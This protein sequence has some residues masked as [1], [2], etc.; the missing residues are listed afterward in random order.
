MYKSAFVAFTAIV[1]SFLAVYFDVYFSSR[2]VDYFK[3][4]NTPKTTYSTLTTMSI[5]RSVVKKV[6]AIEQS[7]G[8]GARVRRSIGSMGLR[9]LTPFL[10]LDHFRIGKG[11]VSIDNHLLHGF[12]HLSYKGFPDHPHRGQATVTYMLEGYIFSEL[13]YTDIYI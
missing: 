1:I 5:S 3:T 4:K 9:N 12:T 8:D 13:I 10:M 6:P 2:T 11:A 7:E